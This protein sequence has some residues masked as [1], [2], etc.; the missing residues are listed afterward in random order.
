LPAMPVNRKAG[1]TRAVERDGRKGLSERLLQRRGFSLPGDV[2]RRR[3]LYK[4]HRLTPLGQASARPG[5]R[6][7]ERFAK[8]STERCF[9][10]A[11]ERVEVYVL[12][13][14]I[15]EPGCRRTPWAAIGLEGEARRSPRAS[16]PVVGAEGGAGSRRHRQD[17]RT[18]H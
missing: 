18:G 8:R 11:V 10:L 16:G 12:T 5:G 2:K 6:A 3:R 13:H 1:A 9:V 14:S 15:V 4:E 17:R 7:P